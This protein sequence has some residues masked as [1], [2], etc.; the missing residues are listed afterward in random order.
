MLTKSFCI[1]HHRAPQDGAWLLG[2]TILPHK[3]VFRLAELRFV[4]RSRS[5][6]VRKL[7]E[8]VGLRRAVEA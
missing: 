2:I 1:T 7:T 4:P 8:R 3:M 6:F 5:Q